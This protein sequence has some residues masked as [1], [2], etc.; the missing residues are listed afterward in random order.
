MINIILK[1][2]GVRMSIFLGLLAVG[3]AGLLAV[4]DKLVE[5]Y[6]PNSEVAS[7]SEDTDDVIAMLDEQDDNPTRN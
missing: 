3:A 6:F 4:S 2:I 5:Y 7:M 1:S